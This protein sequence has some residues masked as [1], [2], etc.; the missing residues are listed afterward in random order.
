MASAETQGKI[1]E[2][3]ETYRIQLCVNF[4]L[5]PVYLPYMIFKDNFSFSDYLYEI[6]P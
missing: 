1:I 4:S 5:F 3:F 6:I 2:K